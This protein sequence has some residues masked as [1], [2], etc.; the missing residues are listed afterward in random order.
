VGIQQ[1]QSGELKVFNKKASKIPKLI[2][3]MPQHTSLV[4]ELTILETLKFFACLHEMDQKNFDCRFDMITELL[5]LPSEDM[6]IRDLSS[7][8]QRRISLAA[9]IIHNPLLLILDEPT[10]G[11]DFLLREKIW[12][13][14]VERSIKDGVTAIITT[15]YISEAANAHRCGFMRNGILIA[16]DEPRVILE[17]MSVESLDEA[18]YEL[19]V[20]G[21]RCDGGDGLSDGEVIEDEIDDEKADESRG[22]RPLV[23]KG[24][25]V[26]EFHRIRRQPL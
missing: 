18:F 14:L 20:R 4:A 25:L 12:D 6:Q 8:Q 2:G 3:F 5:E 7:G 19:C 15:H 23:M 10:V 26:K 13:F 1:P 21:G 17:K 22:F 9:T 24:L 16:E 11:V